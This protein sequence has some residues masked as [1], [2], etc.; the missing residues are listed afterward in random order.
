MSILFRNR[1][2]MR[3]LIIIISF[4]Y[5]L[6]LSACAD[7]T[8]ETEQSATPNQPTISQK[9]TTPVDTS[10]VIKVYVEPSG[11]V[12]A[13]GNPTTLNALD[14]SFKKL[15]ELNG[16]VCYS[17]DNPDKDPPAESMKVIGLAVK[18]RLP[19]RLYTDNTFTTALS[20]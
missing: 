3:R 16:T 5:F 13:N 6:L 10:N 17:R 12:I 18:Y 15:K 8:Q 4:A 20:P 19:I 1:L 7:T 14:S 2:P 9:E 11:Q